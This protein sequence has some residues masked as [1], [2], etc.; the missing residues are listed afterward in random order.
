[1]PGRL[2]DA[3]AQFQEAL[4]L[5]PGDARIWHHL[6]VCWLNLGNLGEAEAAFRQEL[7][8]SPGSPAGQ[9]ALSDVLQQ[10]AGGR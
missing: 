1:M 7:R 9:E 6:G 3:V 5:A 2:G 10:E 8:I 4:R